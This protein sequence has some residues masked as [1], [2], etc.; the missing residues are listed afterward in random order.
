M[1]DVRARFRQRAELNATLD[2]GSVRTLQNRP[3][4]FGGNSIRF[5][6][7]CGPSARH[8]ERSARWFPYAVPT[9]SPPPRTLRYEPRTP[10]VSYPTQPETR[11]RH[12]LS[13]VQPCASD[14]PPVTC[15][16]HR[17]YPGR[18]PSVPVVTCM[19]AR[20][21]N[22]APPPGAA[23]LGGGCEPIRI[24]ESE[25]PWGPLDSANR[26]PTAAARTTSEADRDH[27]DDRQPGGGNRDL[28][29]H[30]ALAATYSEGSHRHSD[31]T[32][33]GIR[34]PGPRRQRAW[35]MKNPT[36]QWVTCAS[37]W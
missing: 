31:P 18:T 9:S 37:T 26:R 11:R 3:E 24:P 8:R 15:R 22:Q 20:W 14:T 23:D 32:P 19:V 16:V 28:F 12:A 6:R 30:C 7:A 13:I 27:V 4:P 33:G 35:T 1:I 10:R 29:R 34:A 21:L 5:T 25:G 17:A 2:S 36:A